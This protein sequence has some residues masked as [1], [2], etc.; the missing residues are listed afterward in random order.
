MKRLSISILSL[1]LLLC[2]CTHSIDN[3]INETNKNNNQIDTVI[4]D[5]NQK[6]NINNKKIN[7]L[8]TVEYYNPSILVA[9]DDYA[10][11]CNWG[12]SID[13]NGKLVLN[14]D[15]DK[16][17]ASIIQ[18]ELKTGKNKI[19]ADID[20]NAF[21]LKDNYLFYIH[22]RALY[23]MNLL[24]RVSKIII[25]NIED[26]DYGII[27]NKIVYVNKEGKL[28]RVTFDGEKEQEL[29]THKDVYS[30][31]I[32]QD[33][34]YYSEFSNGN[35]YY[36][37]IDGTKNFKVLENADGPIITATNIYYASEDGLYKA[38]LDGSN[39]EY[40]MGGWNIAYREVGDYIYYI[41]EQGGVS[42]IDK[43]TGVVENKIM[44]IGFS[45]MVQLGN[46]LYTRY[47][48][49]TTSGYKKMDLTTFEV[50]ESTEI[51]F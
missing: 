26:D 21:I 29:V 28:L 20:G 49:E 14:E 11:Y 42:R 23:K 3:N 51:V 17:I 47:I 35:L 9:N 34:I 37:S 39:P 27:D 45:D 44:N 4:E 2:S 33:K 48:G 31:S 36:I 5:N 8:E 13:D 10:Y 12:Y 50:T 40:I 16:N 22:D 43:E 24:D 19:L 18:Y 30:I 7:K 1:M 15:E 32:Q 41:R 38:D 25:K 6:S 46:H